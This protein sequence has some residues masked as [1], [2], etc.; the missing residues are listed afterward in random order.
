MNWL[1]LLMKKPL[2]MQTM[3]GQN[4]RNAESS[5]Q[6]W[7]NQNQ[8][9]SIKD[10]K[11]LNLHL[12]M[13]I[14]S[15]HIKLTKETYWSVGKGREEQ[16]DLLRILQA[17]HPWHS[18]RLI[19]HCSLFLLTSSEDPFRHEILGFHRQYLKKASRDGLSFRLQ[20]LTI[21]TAPKLP[22]LN[23]CQK[24]KNNTLPPA[25]VVDWICSKL[26]CS[27]QS[28]FL[29]TL[30]VRIQCKLLKKWSKIMIRT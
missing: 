13:M 19:Y 27:G 3:P 11:V 1:N 26:S 24:I 21:T 17:L 25:S 23:L 16:T 20:I 12:L 7:L 30:T 18:L 8:S 9:T 10:W 5:T 28:V 22:S 15:S 4:A 2:S 29:T 14:T 6:Q